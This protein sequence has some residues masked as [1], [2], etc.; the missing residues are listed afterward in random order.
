MPKRF[1]SLLSARHRRLALN[2]VEDE[3]PFGVDNEEPQEGENASDDEMEKDNADENEAGSRSIRPGRKKVCESQQ[4]THPDLLPMSAIT[5]LVKRPKQSKAER[6][7][8]VQTGREG[9]SKFGFQ[10]NRMNPHASTTNREKRKRK[11]F[12]MIKHKVKGKA[13]KRSFRE[14][15]IALREHLKKVAK[16][17]R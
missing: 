6:L 4:L 10:V 14:K 15:Q 16:M 3:E 7:E 9:R 12:Q 5:R 1:A 8:S 11:T 17:K 13:F 2:K